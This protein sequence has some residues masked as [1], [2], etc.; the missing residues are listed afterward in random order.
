MMN[1]GRHGGRVNI[2]IPDSDWT[3]GWAPYIDDAGRRY[4]YLMNK[5]PEKSE[6]WD[7]LMY[8]SLGYDLEGLRIRFQILKHYL[9]DQIRLKREEN[10]RNSFGF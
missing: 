4:T 10:D 7:I 3:E 9:D 2:F 5:F 8:G 6:T 1:Q